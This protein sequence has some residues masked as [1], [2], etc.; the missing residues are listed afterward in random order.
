MVYQPRCSVHPCFEKYY[1]PSTDLMSLKNHSLTRDPHTPF[2][3]RTLRNKYPLLT[4]RDGEA[5]VCTHFPMYP[6]Y[7]V[8]PDI[9]WPPELD[10]RPRNLFTPKALNARLLTAG[11]SALQSLVNFTLDLCLQ[12]KNSNY[13]TP[14]SN[15]YPKNVMP[16]DYRFQPSTLIVHYHAGVLESMDTTR[17]RR[18]VAR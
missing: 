14:K 13:H 11:L 9:S 4:P 2:R 5:E 10:Y 7:A 8:V 3:C 16:I 17:I 18:K 12:P 15:I 6:H 1:L